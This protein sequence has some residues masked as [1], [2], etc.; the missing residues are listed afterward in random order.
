MNKSKK[1]SI[2]QI[3][4]DAQCSPSAI[5]RY[6]NG[7]YLSN[8]LRERIK[9]SID[10]LGY[11]ISPVAKLM[12]GQSNEI[13]IVCDPKEDSIN[14][15]I[16]PTLIF[17]KEKEEIIFISYSDYESKSYMNNLVNII[18][19]KP[20]A[21]V[22]INHRIDNKFSDFLIANQNSSNF[23]VYGSNEKDKYKKYNFHFYFV[24]QKQCFLD[25][26]TKLI[27]DK[28]I[29]NICFVGINYENK[30]CNFSFF[31]QRLEGFKEAIKNNPIKNEIVLLNVNEISSAALELQ[32]LNREGF[33]NFICGSHTIYRA[34]LQI[35]DTQKS[36]ST[37]VGFFS[38]SDNKR[39]FFG[40]VFIDYNQIAKDISKDIKTNETCCKIKKYVPKIL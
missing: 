21:I 34:F 32:K 36:F 22:I 18:S 30:N 25:L 2:V 27:K 14:K 35:I 24:D 23:F 4:R 39:K 40:K 3:A 11:T 10:K 13:Y 12:R 31:K 20:K 29:N 33:D 15:N 9:K 19:R 38:L 1:T 37:D 6:F 8:E 5:S 16:I 28:K 17:N 7:G 26:T